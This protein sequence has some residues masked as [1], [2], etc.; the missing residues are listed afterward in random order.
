MSKYN[1]ITMGFYLVALAVAILSG[2]VFGFTGTH[3]PPMPFVIEI[4]IIPI[5]LVWLLIDT[6]RVSVKRTQTWNDILGHVVGLIINAGFVI[7]LIFPIFN[8]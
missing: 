4:L 2:F 6:I 5:G 8:N 7:C 1:E 3:T